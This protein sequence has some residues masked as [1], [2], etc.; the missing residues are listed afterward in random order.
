MW[1]CGCNYHYCVCALGREQ[2][3]DEEVQ[4]SI[5][6]SKI[7]CKYDTMEYKGL[8]RARD[9]LDCTQGFFK[10]H[11]ASCCA[12]KQYCLKAIIGWQ[13]ARTERQEVGGVTGLH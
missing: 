4:N 7:H 3:S 2:A 5:L 8:K 10:F 9:V 6:Q 13:A 1:N 12:A 11:H